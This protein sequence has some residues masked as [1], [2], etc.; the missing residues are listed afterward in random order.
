MAPK[1]K[2]GYYDLLIIWCEDMCENKY[3]LEHPD[4]SFHCYFKG[5]QVDFRDRDNPTRRPCF[6]CPYNRDY[7]WQAQIRKDMEAK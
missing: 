7:L 4:G 2:Y 5:R 3:I 1:I 6:M